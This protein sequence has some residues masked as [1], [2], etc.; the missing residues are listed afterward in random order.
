MD[1]PPLESLVG[2]QAF[3][4][5]VL[6]HIRDAAPN[7]SLPVDLVIF[8]SILLCLIAKD[9]HLIIRAPDED[10]SLAMRLTV[11]TLSAVFN[12]TT[13][14]IKLKKQSRKSS[15][16]PA[17]PSSPSSSNPQVSPASDYGA[18]LR[19][20]FLQSNGVPLNTTGLNHLA[21]DEASTKNEAHPRSSNI[22]DHNLRTGKQFAVPKHSRRKSFPNNLSA[23]AA[24]SQINEDSLQNIDITAPLQYTPESIASAVSTTSTATHTSTITTAQSILKPQPVYAYTPSLSIPSTSSPSPRLPHAYTD[25]LPISS[26][27]KKTR[28]QGHSINLEVPSLPKKL[29]Q[30]L[31][32]S[33]LEHS[34]LSVQRALATVLGEKK[35]TLD[36]S[37]NQNFTD[38][39]EHGFWALPDIF[40]CVY[41]CPLDPR[42]RPSIHKT[43]L[44]KFAMSV[45]LFIPP[46]IRT[47][48]QLLHFSLSS[49]FPSAKSLHSHVSKSNPGSPTTSPHIPLP[50]QTPPIYTKPL[51]SYGHTNSPGYYNQHSFSHHHHH[52]SQFNMSNSLP[53]ATSTT[54]VHYM[55]PLSIPNSTFA[56]PTTPIR[57]PPLIPSDFLTMVRSAFDRTHVVHTLDLYFADLMSAARHNSRLDGT[58]LT[59]RS[60]KDG[61]DLARASRVVG[62]DLTGMELISSTGV[63]DQDD[64]E[65]AYQEQFYSDQSKISITA[66]HRKLEVSEIDI[67]RVFPRVVSHRIK[68][69]D[70]PEDEILASLLYGAT[71][72]TALP[73]DQTIVL[74]SVKNVLVNILSEV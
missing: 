39:D 69:R 19:S 14:K 25:P 38:E 43:L 59:M 34:E 54:S 52:P 21:H 60:T 51:P 35:V 18:F 1:S 68:L 33:G 13:Q 73:S 71:F 67:A 61:M 3:L 57:L 72:K 53:S 6:G 37:P 74:D 64:E 15:L 63:G 62:S 5:A 31:V 46:S 70:A 11:W 22:H 65:G 56:R 42:T 2:T 28:S 23:A 7:A 10:V 49:S 12:L 50:S 32:V 8:Q 47:D 44:D 29:P 40:I 27:R 55:H 24:H 4:Q 16:R 58:L 41:I 26:R 20:I 30:A 36:G 66:T 17:R 9:K 48:F 45:N